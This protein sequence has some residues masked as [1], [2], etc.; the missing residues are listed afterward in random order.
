MPANGALMDMK[1]NILG[2]KRAHWTPVI[3][4]TPD[5]GDSIVPFLPPPLYVRDYEKAN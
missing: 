1:A 2:A 5:V 3:N 4:P